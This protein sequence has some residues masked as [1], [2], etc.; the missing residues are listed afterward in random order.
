VKTAPSPGT[1]PTDE[2]GQVDAGDGSTPNAPEAGTDAHIEVHVSRDGLAV[3]DAPVM[4][5]DPAGVHV[6]TLYTDADG[7]VRFD[8]VPAGGS[9]TAVRANA[10][11]GNDL[12]TYSGVPMGSVLWI[13][14]AKSQDVELVGTLEATYSN[15][16]A[17]SVRVIDPSRVQREGEN[18][19]VTFAVR[20]TSLSADGTLDL[21]AMAEFG[22]TERQYQVK[23]GLVAAGERPDLLFTTDFDT[24]ADAA[25]I[26]AVFDHDDYGII[27][28]L[29]ARVFAL[30]NGMI[31][32]APG[33]AGYSPQ[34]V[35]TVTGFAYPPF[36]DQVAIYYHVPAYASIDLSRYHT[37]PGVP[38]AGE[39]VEFRQATS[40]LLPGVN[41]DAFDYETFTFVSGWEGLPSCGTATPKA[42]HVTW[43]GFSDSSV[44]YYS[45]WEHWGPYATSFA[46]PEFDPDV[47]DGVWPPESPHYWEA[48]GAVVALTDSYE[49][50]LAQLQRSTDFSTL[51]EDVCI[52]NYKADLYFPD[53]SGQ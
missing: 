38:A 15:T 22:E 24:W 4:Y 5:A 12:T 34:D 26:T 8:D 41:I 27:D 20:N 32:D 49:D 10:M 53:L 44:A 17:D 50:L 14:D 33:R 43:S 11:G 19:V 29:D 3:A 35:Y 47:V 18:G 51:S 31:H 6:K 42:I 28:S 21:L 7:E 9:V 48:E 52:A 46:P 45:S 1:A 13:R 40:E 30:R 36:T 25:T 2:P 23:L 37:L 16:G 39:A